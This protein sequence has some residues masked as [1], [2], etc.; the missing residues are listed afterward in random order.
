MLKSMSWSVPAGMSI[1]VPC[2]FGSLGDHTSNQADVSWS[3][4]PATCNVPDIESPA[5]IVRAVLSN[6]LS[7]ST[8][9]S[10]TVIP[11]R[12]KVL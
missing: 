4:V 12:V 3:T 11:S 7:K 2:Q 8:S 5:L 6:I 10:A 1:F 9:V